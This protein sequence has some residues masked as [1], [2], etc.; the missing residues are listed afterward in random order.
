M[1]RAFRPAMPPFL[2]AFVGSKNARTNAGM[3]GL[4]ACLHVLRIQPAIPITGALRI[5]A[6]YILMQT[7]VI[8]T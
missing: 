2:A 8:S 1:E 3:A 5:A 4:R 6:G 7:E